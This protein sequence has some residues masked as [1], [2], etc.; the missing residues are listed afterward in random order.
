[1]YELTR[2]CSLARRQKPSRSPKKC[3]WWTPRPQR[4]EAQSATRSSTTCLSTAAHSNSWRCFN[5]ASMLSPQ[6]ATMWLAGALPRSQLM[7]HDRNRAAFCWTEPTSTTST[8]RPPGPRG[9]C[10]WAWRRCW[11][12]RCSP[13]PTRRSSAAPPAAS[14]TPSPAPGRTTTTARCSSSTATRRS[15]PATSSTRP[16]GPSRISDETSSAP[17]SAVP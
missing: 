6:E 16:P 7:E 9:G 8:T 14:S 11:S 10:C 3:P 2:C 5:P 4:W 1:M 17:S 13:T 15:T 12:S